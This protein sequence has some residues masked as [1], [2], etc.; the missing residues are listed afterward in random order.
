M[1]S[2]NTLFFSE[3]YLELLP[4]MALFSA[5]VREGG[6]GKAAAAQGV[7]KSYVSKQVAQLEESLGVRLLTRT[8][9]SVHLTEAGELYYERCQEMLRSA[10]LA[11]DAVGSVQEEA[12]GRLHISVPVSFGRDFLHA[13]LIKY[14]ERYPRIDAVLQMSDQQVDIVREGIDLA[15]RV[16]PVHSPDLVIHQLMETRRMVVASPAYL[17][18]HGVPRA[19]EELRAHTCLLYEYQ[20]SPGRWVFQRNGQRVEVQVAGRLIANNG[21]FLAEAACAGLGL[22]WLPDFVAR[23]YLEATTLVPILDSQCKETSVVNAVLPARKHLPAKV[24]ELIR[25][26]KEE[27]QASQTAL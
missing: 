17:E 5:V 6:F 1:P 21:D 20:S 9:R 4:R 7:S 16:G 27:L 26:L 11:Q 25:I 14:L 19:P 2:G 8:T 15:I 18:K 24:R 23:K 10:K 13:P 12:V 3:N 22:A